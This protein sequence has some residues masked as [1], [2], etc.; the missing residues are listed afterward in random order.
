MAKIVKKVTVPPKQN[1]KK[2]TKPAT[3]KKTKTPGRNTTKP[4][5]NLN[6]PL[7]LT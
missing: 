5:R 3:K 1:R 7:S 4:V 2:K 6:D